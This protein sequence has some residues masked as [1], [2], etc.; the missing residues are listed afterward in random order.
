MNKK[1]LED[2]IRKASFTYEDYLKQMQAVRK[3]GSLK[4]LMKMLP[5]ASQF[6]DMLG[7]EDS[8]KDFMKMESII[9]SMTKGERSAKDELTMGRMKR[10]AAGSGTQLHDVTRFSKR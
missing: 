4:S 3:M 9:L 1:E 5:G 6:E 7:M 10:I 8:E 2:K